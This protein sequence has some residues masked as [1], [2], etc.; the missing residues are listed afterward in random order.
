MRFHLPNQPLQLILVRH[1]EVEESYHKVFG[2]SRIDMG[3]S[4]RGH[5]QAAA[6]ARWFGTE[7]IEA[8]YASPMRRVRQTMAP[9]LE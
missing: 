5:E 9:L 4:S 6:V 2:G 3:L 7:Q 8:V 1:G